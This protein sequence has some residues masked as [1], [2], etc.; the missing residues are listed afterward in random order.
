M[1]TT[2]RRDEAPDEE[3][4]SMPALGSPPRPTSG[5]HSPEG[6]GHTK[7]CVTDRNPSLVNE[8]MQPTV[9]KYIILHTIVNKHVLF[10][11]KNFS[12][13]HFCRFGNESPLKASPAAPPESLC[14][15]AE[16]TLASDTRGGAQLRRRE[17]ENAF[18]PGLTAARAPRKPRSGLRRGAGQS[19][20]KAHSEE[21]AIWTQR[22]WD[23]GTN[24]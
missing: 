21:G 9:R 18:P 2:G 4:A 14:G 22:R 13:D 10:N 17:S 7:S 8:R 20:G 19:S 24:W 16:L 3:G 6:S 15:T 1:E 5:E 11:Q 23:L 12:D